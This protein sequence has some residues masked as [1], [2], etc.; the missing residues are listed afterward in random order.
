MGRNIPLRTLIDIPQTIEIDDLSSFTLIGRGDI[1]TGLPI[2]DSDGI[3]IKHYVWVFC[4]VSWHLNDTFSVLVERIDILKINES[5][6]R[7]D[8]CNE[9]FYNFLPDIVR[10]TQKCIDDILLIANRN[11]RGFISDINTI[12]FCIHFDFLNC[13]QNWLLLNV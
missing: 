3:C 7:W 12:Y 11:K 2:N 10:I 1:D 5:V 9:A 8:A 6:N 13:S 4:L